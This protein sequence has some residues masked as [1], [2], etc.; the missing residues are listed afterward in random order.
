MQQRND[1]VP[2]GIEHGE[3]RKLV[4]DVINWD[5]THFT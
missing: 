3:L 5:L 4:S 2:Y 1:K